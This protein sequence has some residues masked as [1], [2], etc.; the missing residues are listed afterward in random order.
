M[1]LVSLVCAIWLFAAVTCGAGPDA[2]SFDEKLLQAVHVGTDGPTLVDY[3]RKRIVPDLDAG[4]VRDLVRQL[5]DDDFLARER[6]SA[7]LV[8]LR[9]LAVPFL[10]QASKDSDIEVVR[11]AE[12][13]LRRIGRGF[14]ANVDMAAA[15]LLAVRKPAGATEALLGFLPFASNSRVADEVQRALIALAVRDGK[16][17]RVLV[18]ALGDKQASK[19]AGAAV[20]LV[21]AGVADTG[22]A[23]RKLLQDSDA[24]VRLRVALALAEAGEKEAIPVLIDVLPEVP[25]PFAWQAEDV[26]FRLADQQAPQASLGA[27]AA[28]RK[29]CRDA[30]ADWWGKQRDKV[31]LGMLAASSRLKGLT[32]LVFLNDGKVRE[33]D[34]QGKTVWEVEGIEFPL[35]AQL[36]ANGHLVCAEYKGNRVTERDQKGAIVWEQKLP[37]TAPL[38]GQRLANGN[39]FI[40]TESGVLEV[41]RANREV[42]SYAPGNGDGLRK[43]MRLRNGDLALVT[44]SG[45]FM[46]CTP[47][48]KEILSF[49]AAVSTNGGRIDVTPEG[50]IIVPEMANNQVVEYDASGKPVWEC[51]V[52]GPIAAVRL[53]NGNTLV[54][55]LDQNRAIEFDGAGREVWQFKGDTR[56]TRAFRR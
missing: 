12:A 29:K 43:G 28:S 15:R 47:A 16:P 5:G 6:A 44:V 2:V 41:D 46:R 14:G 39:T 4:K 38:V 53:P 35:D 54:T 37:N 20:A 33:V 22:P 32:L 56:I 27:D 25:L 48:G 7:A 40:V 52:E 49:P 17:D 51:A 9:T 3:F 18:D 42:F 50:N 8:H 30:W 13:C 31:D 26:L 45:K 21:R 55:T 1:R 11:R 10:E 34:A 19:R 24:L 23:V 36:L